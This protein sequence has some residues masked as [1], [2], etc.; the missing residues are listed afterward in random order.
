MAPL[1]DNRGHFIS[2]GP[3]NRGSNTRRCEEFSAELKSVAIRLPQELINPFVRKIT[4]QVLTGVVQKTPV[5]TGRARGG[6]QVNQGGPPQS[7]PIRLDPSGQAT[8]ADGYREIASL[9]DYP[10]V[11][12]SNNVRYIGYL[13]QGKPGPGSNQAPNGMAALTLREVASQ[14]GDG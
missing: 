9:P 6:W 3:K 11:Y 10:T 1:R 2:S 13:E 8:I 12:I 14:F 5:D 7:S 4:L